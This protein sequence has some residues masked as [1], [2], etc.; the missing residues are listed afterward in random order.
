MGQ[1]NLEK[2]P[3]LGEIK[4]P[5][6]LIS[7]D[8]KTDPE[9][10]FQS[11]FAFFRV[12]DGISEVSDDDGKD[13]GSIG[14]TMGGHV[15]MTRYY[16]HDGKDYESN[17]ADQ[18]VR[19]I[20]DVRDLWDQIEK[21]LETDNVKVQ[22]E[23]IEDIYKKYEAQKKKDSEER[24]EK[25]KKLDEVRE[26]QEEAEKKEKLVQVAAALQNK[27]EFDPDPE[28]EVILKP[29]DEQYEGSKWDLEK[30]FGSVHGTYMIKD[31]EIYEDGGWDL[32][33]DL[34]GRDA[35]FYQYIEDHKGGPT[36]NRDND[37]KIPTNLGCNALFADTRYDKRSLMYTDPD[38]R[39]Q[40]KKATL[41]IT[42]WMGT[43]P[44]AI[45]YYAK[46]KFHALDVHPEGQPDTSTSVF[47]LPL[48]KY[49]TIEVTRKL[50]ASEFKKHPGVYD[51]WYKGD[52]YGG[53]Y[54]QEEAIK[55]GKKVFK[56]LFSED[57]KLK[58]EKSY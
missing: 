34:N 16:P 42:T 49:G 56:D 40:D 18:S 19:V 7:Y 48:Y 57:W 26:M 33:E 2:L 5:V 53:F 11:G 55:A 24:A 50:E 47:D 31:T 39:N 45:H 14:G 21:L 37:G 6:H 52:N 43:S 32:T 54:T 23:G 1:G 25:Q 58:V 35:D 3:K 41:N 51:G 28:P 38:R 9:K 20:I 27:S 17:M 8:D 36:P 46:I 12:A 13:I 22:L 4:V 29:G 15:E 10:R 30:R 44:G